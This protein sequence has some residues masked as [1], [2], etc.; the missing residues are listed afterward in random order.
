MRVLFLTP[1]LPYPP[2]RGGEIIIFNVLR[3]LSVRHEIALVTFYDRPE[4]LAYR[5]ELERYCRRVEMVRRRG[6]LHP[7][8]LMRAL[9]GRSYSISRHLSAEL[10]SML[11]RVVDEWRPDVVQV[12]TFVMSS[13]LDEL[14]PIPTVLHMHDVAWV[15][16]DRMAAVVPFYLQPLVAIEARRIRRDE[17]DA[18]RRSTVCVNVSDTD[19]R[20]L[21]D[22]AGGDLRTVVILPGVDTE[23]V[24][25]VN[26]AGTGS[27][28]V[29]VGSM[30]YVPNVDAVE[31]FVR[32]VLPL[33]AAKV[34][35][36]TF[37]IVGARPAA[38]VQRLAANP[39][40]RV[41]GRVDDV[42]RYYDGAAVAIVP[43]RIGG[44]V[45]IKILE[46]MALGCPV[47]STTIGAEGLGLTDG[48]DLMIADTPQ[49]L[50]AAAVRLLRDRTLRADLAARA[51]ATALQRFSW[52]A[53]G[54]TLE[55][56]Y[57]SIVASD[58]T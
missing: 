10:R 13:Y 35:D 30:S 49:A 45:R 23:N 1:R 12:E 40:V 55:D 46:A 54:H 24:T 37:T 56:V 31:F 28:L 29:F 58:H 6:K 51:R 2:D 48:H 47:L 38:S 7:I 34:P 57:G 27:G 8:V 18:A 26:Q 25:P 9:A 52:S 11:R 36:V 50:A 16:W 22:E 15:M 41:T 43:L 14:Q 42:R 19:R 39:R 17:L 33:I 32:D 4:D 53:V 44:G 5:S 20:R 3:Q 21:T